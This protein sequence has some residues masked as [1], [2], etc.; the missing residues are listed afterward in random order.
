MRRTVR[1]RGRRL[2]REFP[3]R[4]GRAV[5]ILGA[6]P[7]VADLRSALIYDP[8]TLLGAKKERVHVPAAAATHRAET[9]KRRPQVA[10]LILGGLRSVLTELKQPQP[11]ELCLFASPDPVTDAVHGVYR[12]SSGF[13]ELSAE[14]PDMAVDRPIRDDILLG[15][16]LSHQL[17]TRVDL[18]GV[19][20]H[21][22]KQTE[23]GGGEDDLATVPED[24]T[25]V[26]VEL[27]PAV[28]ENCPLHVRL[29]EG[30]GRCAS[31][32]GGV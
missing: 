9:T 28:L 19:R 13:R 17:F 11:P 31:S 12:F 29:G 4:A 32:R 6:L 3:Y 24:L 30:R 8:Q 27:Q 15:I 2:I 21:R 14:A 22:S 10:R 5:A 16:G 26:Q 20:D 18:A 7:C 23:L 25:T 1:S